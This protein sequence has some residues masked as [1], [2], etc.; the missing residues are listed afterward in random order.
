MMGHHERKNMAI[1]KSGLPA[2]VLE[3]FDPRP[4][5]PFLA[6]IVK[7]KHALPILGMAPFV[8]HFP[9]PGDPEYAP[10]RNEIALREDR[11]FRCKEYAAQVSIAEESIL[12]RC[13]HSVRSCTRTGAPRAVCSPTAPKRAGMRGL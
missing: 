7:K 5:L 8:G 9:E 3:L 2:K 4:E 10:P 6:P 1:S 11:P 12:E 13:V